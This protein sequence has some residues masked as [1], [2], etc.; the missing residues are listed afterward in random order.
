MSVIVT[1]ILVEGNVAQHRLQEARECF[2]AL[3][4]RVQG[5]ILGTNA[6]HSTQQ[7]FVWA[8]EPE[9]ADEIVAAFIRFGFTIV[10]RKVCPEYIDASGEVRMGAMLHAICLFRDSDSGRDAEPLTHSPFVAVAPGVFIAEPTAVT[11]RIVDWLRNDDTDVLVIDSE[12][13]KLH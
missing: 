7:M 12:R 10:E 2:T 9:V 13:S 6:V 8:G 3:Y 5:R 1:Q 4:E 11:R